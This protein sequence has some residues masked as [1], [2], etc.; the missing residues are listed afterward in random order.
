MNTHTAEQLS[1]AAETP[2]PLAIITAGALRHARAELRLQLLSW[3]LI[4][5]LFFPV[6]GLIVLFFLR[7][8][9][10]MG[11]SVSVAEIGAPGLVTMSLISAGVLGV[12]GQL[13]TEQDDGT[14]LRAKAVP[15]G[16][17][18]HLV[19]TML[20][21]IVTTV[22]PMVLL[23]VGTSVLFD[24]APRGATGWLTFTWVSLLGLTATMPLGAV[25]GALL[26]SMVML[27]W[28]SVVVYGGMAISGVFYPID[29]LPG[30]VQLVGKVLPTYWVGVGMRSSMLPPEAAALEVG[31]AWQSWL[32]VLVLGLWA[33]AGLIVA[34]MA[35]RRMARRQ[36]GSVVA[37][38]RERFLARGY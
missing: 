28:V 36:S 5:W 27:W 20:V 14:L 10:V 15:H 16:I 12:A 2:K 29:A 25:L 31:G 30:W 3:N 33:A 11:S 9:H 17:P 8:Q 34:P 23:L 1:L 22:L 37:A 38:A 13:G 4:G 24:I 7:D 21:Y 19:G 26:R 6:L 18:S 32:V 35:L